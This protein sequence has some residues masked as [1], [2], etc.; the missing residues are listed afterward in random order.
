MQSNKQLVDYLCSIGV[1]ETSEIIEAFRHVDRA[2]FVLSAYKDQAYND[3]PIPI[4]FGQTI[5]QPFTVAFMLELLEPKAGQEILD[6]GSGSGWT[7]A[8]LS[9]VVGKKGKVI[10][11][12]KN[13]ELVEFGQ[14][15]LSKYN[16]EN[17]RIKYAGD[18]L[19]LPGEKFDC[20]LVSAA[21]S[22]YPE[23]LED[24]LKQ[25]GIMIIPIENSIFKIRKNKQGEIGK[26]EF[27]G[28]AFV[29]LR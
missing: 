24:Q 16:F 25:N 13:P 26:Q 3:H 22:H 17:S 4:G 10:G 2:D 12:E 9:Y 6:I 27:E 7:T 21:A 29:P 28:F 8:L 1:L 5:S 23:E 11:L 19:G 14:Q 15:N 20:I 18:K